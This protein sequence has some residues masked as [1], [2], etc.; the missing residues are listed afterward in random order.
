[1]AVAGNG[2]GVP[3]SDS[4]YILKVQLTA[5]ALAGGLDVGVGQPEKP[6]TMPRLLTG[7]PQ[8][9]SQPLE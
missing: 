6:G 1:M 4:G 3:G 9:D 5:L 8:R 2:S 7:A